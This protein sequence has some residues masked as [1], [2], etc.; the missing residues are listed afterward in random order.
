MARKLGFFLT[1]GILVGA[2][3]G[4]CGG[5]GPKSFPGGDSDAG[6][7]TG[8]DDSGDATRMFGDAS[9]ELPVGPL[10]LSPLAPSIDVD[11]GNGTPTVQFTASVAG[12]PVPAAF[13]IDRGEIGSFGAT[14]LLAPSG[15]VGGT[16]NVTAVWQGRSAQTTVTVRLH[17]TQ[18]GASDPPLGVGG[19]GT[20]GPVAMGTQTVLQ[21]K[22]QADASLAWLYPYDKTV[23]PQGLLAPLLQWSTAQNYDAVYIKLT[24]KAFFYD[25]YFAKT[26][27]PFV[28]HPISQDAWK[29]LTYSNQGE[30][31]SVTLVF[32]ANGQAYGPLTET[33]TI[34]QGTLKGT[35][36]Y[37]SYGTKLVTN[38]QWGNI[39]FGGA[40]L[41]VKPGKASPV[42]AAGSNTECRVCHNVSADGSHLVTSG[43]PAEAAFSYDLKA[44]VETPLSPQDGTFTFGAL[45]TDGS[46]LLS[47]DN[48]PW[49][50]GMPGA[51]SAASGLYSM[52]SGAPVAA[53]GLPPGLGAATPVFSPDGK[54]VAF[55]FF[56]G[57]GADR[58]S[59]A[60][61]DFDAKTHTFSNLRMLYTP[62]QP[63]T[64]VWP[65]FMPTNEAVVFELETRYNGRDFGG[66][67]GDCDPAESCNGAGSQGELWWLDVGTKKATRLD[68]A[69]GHG[70]LPTGPNGHGDDA[71]LAFEPTVNPVV[72]GGYSWV[73]FTSRRLYG[74]V[75]TINPYDSDPR[76]AP[77]VL[78]TPTPKK[79]WVAAIEANPKPGTDPSHPAFYLPGQELLAGNSRGFWVVDPCEPNGAS[80]ESGDEC[81][82]GYCE[83]VDGGMVCSDQKPPCSQ[84]FDKCTTTADCCGA[85]SGAQCL[86][87]RCAFVNQ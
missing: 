56:A 73:V 9:D 12:H 13:T 27:A 86:N 40:T 26:A 82:G 7:T 25:G 63:G 5:V 38:Y 24:E 19:E 80:C 47:N 29:A 16:A 58:R 22:P 23:W 8:D 37:Q 33:W 71:T 75:A 66:T 72:S 41:A 65:A 44:N 6:M 11:F 10:D 50:G 67:R 2:L 51:S 14:G 85:Q 68:A 69:N 32:A 74:N 18:N 64:A 61:M 83:S 31:V 79:L 55:N 49:P 54:H 21:G 52:P 59:L 20:G 3:A 45:F 36:Y 60:E 70:Y 48:T 4:A 57:A 77:T 84:Q 28:H 62:P 34:A 30:P 17:F 87:G 53:Q 46:L 42:V 39:S 15:K 1:A 76:Y 81:C 35:V 43:S 78:T